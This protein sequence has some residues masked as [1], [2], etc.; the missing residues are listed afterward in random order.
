MSLLHY[1]QVTFLTSAP[2]L[3]H[4]PIDIG[5]EVAF[6]GRSNVGKSSVINSLTNVKQLARVAKVPGRT[7]AINF[8]TLTKDLRLVDLPGYGYAKVAKSLQAAWEEHLAAYLQQRESLVGLI[9]IMDI[10]HPLKASDVMLLEYVGDRQLPVHI[11]LNKSDKLKRNQINMT[12]TEV[13]QVLEKDYPLV[14]IQAFSCFNK[15]GVEEARAKITQLLQ[16]PM[17]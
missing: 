11:L 5:R 12:L 4:C 7:Q 15:S 6:V 13:R 3:S 17:G 14:T 2:S 1:N 8:F 16:A 10:R 9:L